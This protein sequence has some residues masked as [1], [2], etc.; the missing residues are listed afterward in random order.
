MTVGHNFKYFDGILIKYEFYDF[1][2]IQ[3]SNIHTLTIFILY[4]TNLYYIVYYIDHVIKNTDESITFISYPDPLVF[5][6][7][8]V[9]T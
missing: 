2:I 8:F 1:N 4:L 6:L 9:I 3:F 7:V 5:H